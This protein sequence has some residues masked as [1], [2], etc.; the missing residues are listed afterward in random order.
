MAFE[1]EEMLQKALV[2]IQE[3]GMMFHSEVFALLPISEATYYSW[4]FNKEE[5][6]LEAIHNNRTVTKRGIRNKMYN[7]DNPTALIA[8]YKLIGDE[9]EVRR[10]N[11]ETNVIAIPDRMTLEIV[12]VSKEDLA[13]LRED[14]KSI[15]DGDVIEVDEKGNILDEG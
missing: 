5:H 1:K 12:G 2:L 15:T 9:D 7:S 13:E 6:I 11:N 4:G 14:L 8:L 10:L 3:H